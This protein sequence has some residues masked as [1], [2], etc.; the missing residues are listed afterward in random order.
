M[1]LLI[2]VPILPFALGKFGCFPLGT[3]RT[4]ELEGIRAPR[5][6]TGPAVPANSGTF[7]SRPSSSTIRPRSSR[8][9]W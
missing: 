7:A 3:G 1:D 2:P 4:D 9:N 5:R 6:I 8:P